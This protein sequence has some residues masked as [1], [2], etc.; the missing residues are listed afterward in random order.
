MK[1]LSVQFTLSPYYGRANRLEDYTIMHATNSSWTSRL[2]E[3]SKMYS[4]PRGNI[5][6]IINKTDRLGDRGTNEDE[7]STCLSMALDTLNDTIWQFVSWEKASFYLDY[8]LT[9]YS[10]NFLSRMANDIAR[11]LGNI[12]SFTSGYIEQLQQIKNS[13][14]NLISCNVTE[15]YAIYDDV[16]NIISDANA[17]IAAFRNEYDNLSKDFRSDVLM[18]SYDYPMD[19]TKEDYVRWAW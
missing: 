5:L 7:Q 11:N 15:A 12:E 9:L 4:E 3:L 8:S 1:S 10:E 13:S 14:M 18:S 2:Y 16:Q 6:Q 17:S 19:G